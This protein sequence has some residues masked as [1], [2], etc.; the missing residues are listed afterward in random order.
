[1]TDEELV[2]LA[3][4]GDTSAYATL[5]RRHFDAAFATARRLTASDEDAEDACQEAF[6]RGWFRLD[7]CG[8][9][10]RVGAWLIQ[11]TRHHAH[12]VRRYQRLRA[13]VA[14]EDVPAP[15]SRGA[16]SDAV[17]QAELGRQL[18]EAL[19]GLTPV[20]RDVVRHHDVDGWTHGQ[21]AKALDISEAMSRRHLSDA[22]AQLRRRLGA[23]ARDLMIEDTTI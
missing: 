16:T 8:D 5:M 12:N 21:I 15:V 23:A 7:R 9:P 20:K 19:S 11:I 18:R 10:A 4:Q 17:E 22:R 2:A 6:A 1:V 13:S 14:L 3:L